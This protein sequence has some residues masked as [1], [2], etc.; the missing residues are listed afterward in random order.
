MGAGNAPKPGVGSSASR[1]EMASFF[2]R[3]N[4]S[5]KGRYL[6]TATL[7]AD[8]ASNFAKEHRW[9]YFPSVALGW[10]FVEE[11]FMTPLNNVLSMVNFV[12]VMVKLVIPISVTGQSVI[13]R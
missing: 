3:F 5:F 10:R 9:G 7:R 8:G 2:G 6:L 1:N 12:L 13:I 11:S 4:Y